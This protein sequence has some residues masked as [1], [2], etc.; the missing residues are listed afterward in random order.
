MGEL[1]KNRGLDARLCYASLMF[2][3][4]T[5]EKVGYF[6]AVRFGADEDFHNRLK[7]HFGKDA[8]MSIEKPLYQALVRESSLSNQESPIKLDTETKQVVKIS[9]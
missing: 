5:L 1:V 3:S 4:D 7:A 9:F 8:L 2:R 6:D